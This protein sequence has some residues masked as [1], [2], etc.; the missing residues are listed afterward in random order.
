MFDLAIHTDDRRLAVGLDGRA[1]RR[2]DARG[3]QLAEIG[4]DRVDS[5]MQVGDEALAMPR[6]VDHDSYD[7]DAGD[8]GD[9]CAAFRDDFFHYGRDFANIHRE[10]PFR[11]SE[12]IGRSVLR[13][14]MRACGRG[15]VE[16]AAARSNT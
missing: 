16:A 5:R 14:P 11:I 4:G 2:D 8:R 3:Q 7:G 6:I 12:V 13:S 9:G 1:E 15:P 10:R